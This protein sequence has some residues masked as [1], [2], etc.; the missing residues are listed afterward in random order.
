MGTL[1]EKYRIGFVT[2]PN[3]KSITEGLRLAIKSDQE[4]RKSFLSGMKEL[5]NYLDFSKCVKTF[6]KSISNIN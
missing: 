2:E 4:K 6:V 5:E 1:A 3:S